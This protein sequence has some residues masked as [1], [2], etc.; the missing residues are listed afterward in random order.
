M[1][2][3]KRDTYI[4][5]HYLYLFNGI[6]QRSSIKFLLPPPSP[7]LWSNVSCFASC[8]L[9]AM[10]LLLWH[11]GAEAARRARTCYNY[12][13]T[14]GRK[15]SQRY[16]PRARGLFFFSLSYI[17]HARS[18]YHRGITLYFKKRKKYFFNTKKYFFILIFSYIK[19]HSS[20]F[21]LTIYVRSRGELTI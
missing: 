7:R 19:S 2:M 16:A 17:L 20:S 14:T 10:P 8:I 6:A 3:R 11:G 21:T 15:S 1:R 5:T 12:F 18:K 4:E 13:T 9:R